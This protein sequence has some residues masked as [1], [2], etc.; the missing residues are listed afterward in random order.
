MNYTC[1][2]T[3]VD[4]L[5][6]IA[7]CHMLAFPDSVP[8][9]LG[10]SFVVEMLRWYLSAPN[11]FLF[12]IEEDHQ[13]IGYC[14]GYVKNETDAYGAASGMTQ[15]GFNAALK[16]MI[17]KP[18]LAFHPDIRSRYAFI[19]T[20]IKRKIFKQRKKQT[21]GTSTPNE[22][23]VPL[24]TAGLI[25]IGV[26]PRWQ[27]KG[28]GSILQVEFEKRAIALNAEM[29]QFSVR[30]NNDQAISSYKRNGWHIAEEQHI[31]YLMKKG[32]R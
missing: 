13:C 22:Y 31:S 26:C 29:L 30:K 2:E 16:A 15:F 25:V 6:K 8:V 12:W 18:W 24:K 11:K 32:I 21:Q 20:N 19:L 5:E 4:D 14:G 23:T 17:K 10:K 27:K 1:K 7:V 3:T 28:L 9:L